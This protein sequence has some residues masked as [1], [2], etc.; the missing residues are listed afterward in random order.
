MKVYEIAEQVGYHNVDYFHKKFKKYVGISPAEYR[1]QSKESGSRNLFFLPLLLFLTAR[2]FFYLL[3]ENSLGKC[4]NRE[5]HKAGPKISPNICNTVLKLKKNNSIKRTVMIINVLP[6]YFLKYPVNSE[7]SL[8]WRILI[9]SQK[10]KCIQKRHN[11]KKRRY[12][13]Y[14]EKYN[15]RTF[16]RYTINS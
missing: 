6:K 10:R 14:N 4:C 3:P 12:Q 7:S 16:L 5:H 11:H 1:K 15:R 8:R 2:A 13:P 9:S